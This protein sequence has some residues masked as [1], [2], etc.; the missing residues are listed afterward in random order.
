MYDLV[1]EVKSNACAY[2][3][4]DGLYKFRITQPV[5]RPRIPSLL[6]IAAS[7]YIP[8]FSTDTVGWLTI[9]EKDRTP[10]RFFPISLT[11]D[12]GALDVCQYLGRM[13]CAQFGDTAF[14]EVRCG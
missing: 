7:A 1:V 4:P 6:W 14:S 9:H 2:M 13:N 5:R 12:D 10:M 8:F 11:D 3:S